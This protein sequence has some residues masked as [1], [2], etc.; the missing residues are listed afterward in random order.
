M[1]EKIMNNFGLKLL[2][3][4]LG[5]SLWFVVNN[6]EDP[7]KS[8]TFRNVTVEI[9]NE[10]AIASLDKVF[11]V[12]SGGIINVTVSGKASVL[13]NITTADIVAVA[14]LKNLSLTNAVQIKL[15]CP[16]YEGVVLSSDTDVLSISLEDEATEQ[17][18]VDVYTIG[19]L[20]EGYALGEV[21]VRP[22]L[23][24][25]SGAK[26]LIERVSEVRVE[27]DV[28]NMAM[29]FVRYL[30]PKAYD[31]NG[32]LMDN[33]RINFG[34][35]KIKVSVQVNETKKIPVNIT[36]EGKPEEGYYV[37]SVE[38]EPREIVVTGNEKDLAKIHAVN[39]SYD[40]DGLYQDVETELD[41][42]QYLPEGIR[43]VGDV[44]NINVK[45]T[46]SKQELQSI[47]IPLNK[48]EI[49]N[50]EEELELTYLGEKQEIEILAVFKNLEDWF[51]LS[52][53]DVVAYLDLSGL[54][55][56]THTVKL[57]YEISDTIMI[58]NEITLEITL[59]KKKE[60]DEEDVVT[61][62]ETLSVTS[63]PE[64]TVAPSSEVTEEEETEETE[65][66][67]ELPEETLEP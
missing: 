59:R 64:V 62:K 34:T 47:R 51:E 22:N 31:A 17:Y 3:I 65:E 10:E 54:D 16:K 35:D 24:K 36:A 67:I 37:I 38:Y 12:Q 11:E 2:A 32:K 15:S 43:L 33:S 57:S 63:T 42:Y 39:I 23:I 53:E 48:I 9:L 50:L 25:V 5:I 46:I 8:K 27:V 14:D 26:S 41:L 18:K 56:G 21:K 30:E 28:S 60:E 29:G 1:K 20:P 58:E 55:V 45:L 49:R 7:V 66:E 4:V 61:P 44:S 40:V 19:N 13:R 6:I 52:A